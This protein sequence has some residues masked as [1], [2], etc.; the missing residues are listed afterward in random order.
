MAWKKKKKKKK[1]RPWA[2]HILFPKHACQISTEGP[3]QKDFL[4]FS[5]E[6]YKLLN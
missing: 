1:E 3:K 6:G 5:G 2:L 4:P